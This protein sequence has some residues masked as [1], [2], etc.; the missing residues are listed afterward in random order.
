MT[1]QIVHHSI[2]YTAFDVLSKILNVMK[3]DSLFEL[4]QLNQA[5]SSQDQEYEKNEF[6]GDSYLEERVSSLVLK[7]LRKYEQIPFE[8]YSGLRIHTVKNQTLGEIFDSLHLGDAKTFE[9][10]KKGDLVESIIGG[11]V[12][13]SQREDAT[14]FLLYAHALIDYTFYHSSYNYFLSNP[15]KHVKENVVSDIQ[16]WFKNQLSFY[17]SSL[18]KYQNDPENFYLEEQHVSVDLFD[19]RDLDVNDIDYILNSTEPLDFGIPQEQTQDVQ[20][21]FV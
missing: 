11:C 10:K 2:Q 8:M 1:S 20:T 17:R 19:E 7:F 4:L 21:F 5:Y 18:E 14:L 16:D 6:Y 12:L 13:L 15:P 9:K 3:T